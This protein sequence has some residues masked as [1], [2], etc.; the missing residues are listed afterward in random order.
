MPFGRLFLTASLILL[1]LFS[2]APPAQAQTPDLPQRR[3][4]KIDI[5]GEAGFPA[6]AVF[7][8]TC[9][10][11]LSGLAY[12]PDRQF[13]YALSDD[14]SE[15]QP[16]RFYTL[17]IDLAGGA[18]AGL[19]AYIGSGKSYLFVSQGDGGRVAQL[20]LSDNG[21]GRVTASLI[22]AL[23]LPNLNQP[24]EE[25][26]PAGGLVVDRELGF[27]Y[28]ALADGS[29]ILKYQFGPDGGEPPSLVGLFRHERLRPNLEG[30]ALY[31]GPTGAGYLIASSRGDSSYALFER[32][33]DNAY[34]G[35]FAIAA[36]GPIDPA[37]APGGAGLVNVNLGPT[38]P[39]GLM[40]VRDGA[41]DPAYLAA[42][43]GKLQNSHTNFKFVPWP[44]IANAFPQP[45]L[46]DPDGYNPRH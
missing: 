23:A 31:Y 5:L 44:N 40:V 8:G 17:T 35:S 18:C 30:L 13:Y 43:G 36:N 7:A 14:R 25:A 27:L 41:N 37:S 19:A 9:I 3:V 29:A 10:G 4:V 32:A 2:A 28:V 42:A 6:G 16:A 38:Y 24:G 21:A 15:H 33:G 1:A 46:I 11:G 20:E 22:R 12:D 34:L 45:P 39:F 26:L